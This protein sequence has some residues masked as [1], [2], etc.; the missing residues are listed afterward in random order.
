MEIGKPF[1]D[2]TSYLNGMNKTLQDKLFFVDKLDLNKKYLFVDY[3]CA[4]GILLIELSKILGDNHLYV[5]YDLSESMINLA[6]EKCPVDSNIIFSSDYTV[7]K[8]IISNYSDYSP[9][10]ILSSV[11]H[12]IF[13]YASFTNIELWKDVI[14]PKLYSKIIVRD[15]MSATSSLRSTNSEIE[16]KVRENKEYKAQLRE[17]ENLWGS[18]NRVKSLLHFLLKYKY[19]INWVRELVEDYLPI[20]IEDFNTQMEIFGYRLDY[21]EKFKI[22]YLEN[23]W[24]Q[25]FG[26]TIDDTT[27]IKGIYNLK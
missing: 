2:L 13:S 1:K 19:K 14:Q 15:M 11:V 18:I 3:G 21:F 7:V 23:I 6:K 25:D 5:G 10:L 9:T 12:E 26:I 4:N 20:C 8:S 17:F 24:Y 22:P 27:H 16:K